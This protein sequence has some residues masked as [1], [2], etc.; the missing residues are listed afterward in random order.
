MGCCLAARDVYVYVCVNGYLCICIYMYMYILFLLIFNWWI[1]TIRWMW[2]SE[3]MAIGLTRILWSINDTFN[4]KE[5]IF[6]RWIDT[7]GVSMTNSIDWQNRSRVLVS[8]LPLIHRRLCSAMPLFH[9]ASSAL[10]SNILNIAHSSI[11][12]DVY[13]NN[14]RKNFRKVLCRKRLPFKWPMC[15]FPSWGHFFL[16]PLGK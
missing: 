11:T 10:L 3:S 15:V 6:Y 13:K 4:Q 5:K 12:Y 9:T 1:D 14:F 8:I 16:R 2:T 7:I